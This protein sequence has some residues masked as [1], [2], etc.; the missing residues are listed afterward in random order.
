MNVYFEL[1][2]CVVGPEGKYFAAYDRDQSNPIGVRYL[3]L[4]RNA[5]RA[6]GEHDD[7]RVYFIKNRHSIP[8][9]TLVDMKEFFLD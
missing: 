7:G 2:D 9:N 6:W 8:H 1:A 3:G 5:E 4:M